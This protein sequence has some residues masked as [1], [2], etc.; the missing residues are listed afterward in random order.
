MY[1]VDSRYL[2]PLKAA[3][4]KRQY[5]ADYKSVESPSVWHGT[6]ATVVPVEKID[7]FNWIGQGGVFN[8]EGRCV[9]E[10]IG[11]CCVQPG[12]ARKA[13]MY[14]DEKVVYCGYLIHHWGHF[15]MEGAARLWYFLENDTSIDKY[16]FV[17]DAGEKRDIQGNYKEFFTLLGIWDQLE[18]INQPV[19]YREI[20]VPE[21]AFH[22]FGHYSPKFLDIFDSIVKHVSA[23]EKTFPKK[24]YMSRCALP[25]HKDVDFGF[26]AIDDFFQRNGYKILYPEQLSLSEMICYIQA[27]DT[28]GA[29]S[30]SLLHNAMFAQQGKHLVVAERCAII[31]DWLPPMV[32]IKELHITPVDTN[33]PIYTVA[34]SG[35]FIMGY[36]DL[37]EQYARDHGLVPPSPQYLNKKYLRSCFVGYMKSYQD[38][39]RYRI[40]MEQYLLPEM[41]YHLEAYEYGCNF[42]GEYLRGEKPFLWHHY[43]E[44]HY[45]KQ[46]A[47]RFL[48][49]LGVKL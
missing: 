33:I 48:K 31:D 39:Y 11:E 12:S 17:L 6:N 20:V 28:V 42:Y 18:I 1:Q 49:H 26:E 14:R 4:L 10:S 40:F 13:E 25:K 30:G 15:L 34:M 43:F 8:S 9:A 46:F 21:L 35:P 45:W 5:E 44:I 41:D 38:L 2:R 32:R 3:A 24:I 29:V 27:A 19:T 22:R 37:V 36:N 23:P 47:K 7:Q 16:V